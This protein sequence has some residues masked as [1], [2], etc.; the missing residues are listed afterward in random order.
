[1]S[2]ETWWPQLQQDSRDWLVA[3]NGE[4]LDQHILQ[5][6]EAVGG[7]IPSQAWWVGE[8]APDGLHLSDA[9]IDWVEEAANGEVPE[10]PFGAS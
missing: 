7:P 8:A 6:I 10:P 9:A 2:L 3:H 5:D 4:V 1:M